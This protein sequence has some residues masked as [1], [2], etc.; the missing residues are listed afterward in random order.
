MNNE[1][2]LDDIAIIEPNN[3]ICYNCSNHGIQNMIDGCVTC[4]DKFSNYKENQIS[5]LDEVRNDIKIYERN[6]EDVSP[7]H[8]FEGFESAIKE[9]E[10]KYNKDI[11]YEFK[12]NQGLVKELQE[13]E[14]EVAKFKDE[15][16]QKDIIIEF[17]NKR[18]LEIQKDRKDRIN[19]LYVEIAKLKDENERI[20]Y[21]FD[22]KGGIHTVHGRYSDEDDNTEVYGYLYNNTQLSYSS[23]MSTGSWLNSATWLNY[24][25][26]N[27]YIATGHTTTVAPTTTILTTTVVTTT[28]APTTTATPT[29]T[30]ITTTTTA[31]TTSATTTILELDY[32]YDETYMDDTYV[33]IDTET[34]TTVA[35]TTV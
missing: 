34:T 25:F 21:L 27:L 10:E 28:V 18:I 24:I 4:S 26:S 13:K 5:K 19:N 32:L 2:N 33:L 30:G 3:S 7:E 11:D 29:T 8:I 35:T 31:T 12:R 15:I 22:N 1:K 17:S 16:E 14:D 6:N 23:N 9:M 20:T